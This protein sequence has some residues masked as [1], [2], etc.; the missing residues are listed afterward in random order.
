MGS[1]EV[2]IH[3]LLVVSLESSTLM[4]FCQHQHYVTLHLCN[5]LK[6]MNFENHEH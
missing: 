2:Q 3:F 5:Q 6:L 4:T 1:G